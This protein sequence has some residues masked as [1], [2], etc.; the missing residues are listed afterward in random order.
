MYCSNALSDVS[1]QLQGSENLDTVK[2]ANDP[3]G[4]LVR[5]TRTRRGENI[6]VGALLLLEVLAPGQRK[7]L[8]IQQQVIAGSINDA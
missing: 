2:S 8:E 3:F 5:G 4:K 1:T 7:L 6:V